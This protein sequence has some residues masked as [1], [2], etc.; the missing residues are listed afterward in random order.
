M[1]SCARVAYAHACVWRLCVLKVLL[2]FSL[3]DSQSSHSSFL[4][5]IQPF[6]NPL[7]TED[8]YVFDLMN[9]VPFLK[10]YGRHPV[11]GAKLDAKSL[12]R[13]N[14]RK[15]ATD[16]YHC[17]VMFNIFNKNSHIVAVKTTGNVFSKEA[18]DELNIKVLC[19]SS[20]GA[21][22]PWRM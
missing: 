19:P 1:F 8:G 21:F 7:C 20:W 22:C 10:K 18:V 3:A 11:T 9:I 5:Y 15:N 6:E 4:P 2:F 17:P 13:L 14:F 12:I 16:K